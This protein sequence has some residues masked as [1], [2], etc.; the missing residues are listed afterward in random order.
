M[1]VC[2]P[3]DYTC[4]CKCDFLRSVIP[5]HVGVC[6]GVHVILRQ[7]CVCMI[8]GQACAYV[9]DPEAVC[10]CVCLCVCV[11]CHLEAC[12]SAA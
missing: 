1:Y 8:L 2:D 6:A 7:V 9:C 5:R 3:E 10:A 12:V 11:C 4:V